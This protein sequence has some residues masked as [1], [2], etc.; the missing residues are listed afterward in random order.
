MRINVLRDRSASRIGH[1][2]LPRPHHRRDRNFP[3]NWTSYSC[4]GAKCGHPSVKGHG[5]D[6]GS[7]SQKQGIAS[8]EE[9]EKE[10]AGKRTPTQAE[11]L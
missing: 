2:P 9:E 8:V 4:G 1:R 5:V 7:K 6:E 10:R 11:S 3:K